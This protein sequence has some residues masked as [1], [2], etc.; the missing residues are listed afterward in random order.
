M[1]RNLF[2]L[3][4]LAAT[5]LGTCLPLT[6]QSREEFVQTEHKLHTEVEE[7]R[8]L[9][10]RIATLEQERRLAIVAGAVLL[11]LLITFFCLWLRTVQKKRPAEQRTQPVAT[12]AEPAGEVQV[13]TRPAR[14]LQSVANNLVQLTPREKELLVLINS[15][16]TL[17]EQADKMCLGVNTIR[18]YRQKLNIKLGAHN[19][20]QLLQNAKALHLI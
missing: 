9:K 3:M 17:P 4:L 1:K 7:Y 14:D 10:T 15:G 20:V 13:R 11:L 16:L 5:S 12:Q 18:S 2:T 6:G 8:Y 19:T